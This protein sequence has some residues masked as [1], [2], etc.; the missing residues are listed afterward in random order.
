MTYHSSLMVT[1]VLNQLLYLAKNSRT[2]LVTLVNCRRD[3]QATW[4]CWRPQC[5]LS[6]R[7]PVATQND[8][9]NQPWTC[10]KP[11]LIKPT[12]RDHFLWHVALLDRHDG[13]TVSQHFS[14][15]LWCFIWILLAWQLAL[16]TQVRYHQEEGR[17]SA[18]HRCDATSE[19]REGS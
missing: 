6:N 12:N 18:A 8:Y 11:C 17:W 3:S 13:K 2:E 5:L 4:N 16:F 15:L 14:E 7:I 10:L 9:Q 1:H 19:G